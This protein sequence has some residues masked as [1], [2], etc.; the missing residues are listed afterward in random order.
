MVP[1]VL[2]GSASVARGIRP[3]PDGRP[4]RTDTAGRPD[5]RLYYAQGGISKNW[6][7]LGNTVVYGE[8]ARVDDGINC[9]GGLSGAA[10]SCQPFGGNE[11]DIITSSQATVWGIGIVQNIDAA[12]L[13]LYVSYRRYSADVLSPNATNFLQGTE[14]Y[15]DMDVVMAGGRIRF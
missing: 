6:T 5:T 3:L 10:Q 14:G 15:S 13:E 8:W 12:A 9:T 7:G 1:T 2:K 11:N 4:A